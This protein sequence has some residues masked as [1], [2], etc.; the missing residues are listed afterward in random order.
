MG[1]LDDIENNTRAQR[2]WADAED[3]EWLIARVR[4]LEAALT[5]L[6]HFNCGHCGSASVAQ[7]ALKED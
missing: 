6:R 2:G 3:T 1:K 5:R 7:G 4:K